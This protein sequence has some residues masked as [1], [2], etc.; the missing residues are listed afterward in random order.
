LQHLENS[1]GYFEY[2]FYPS[3]LLMKNNQK[4][5][6]YHRLGLVELG[7]QEELKETEETQRIII[8]MCDSEKKLDSLQSQ[9]QIPLK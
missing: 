7:N 5:N 2:F 4:V 8:G 1:G 3:L 9:I 6:I